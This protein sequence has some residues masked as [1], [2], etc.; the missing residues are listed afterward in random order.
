MRIRSGDGVEDLLISFESSSVDRLAALR[1]SVLSFEKSFSMGFRSGDRA[2]NRAG[3]DRDDGLSDP[4]HFVAAEA[5]E[6]DEVSCLERGHRN[7]STEARNSSPSMGPSTTIGAVTR[8]WR[9]P[10]TKVVVCQPPEALNRGIDNP[11]ERAH[12]SCH[13]GR[14]PGFIDKYQLSTSIAGCASLHARRAAAR[15]RALLAGVQRF[16]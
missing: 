14:G 16:F 1:S 8:W 6:D 3:A 5:I 12:S 15:P 9:R 10:A 11:W 2:A 13:V 4:V 7:C